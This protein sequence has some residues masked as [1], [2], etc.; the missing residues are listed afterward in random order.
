MFFHAPPAGVYFH[1]EPAVT[2]LGPRALVY[3]RYSEPSPESTPCCGIWPVGCPETACQVLP[4][5]V[6]R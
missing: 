2:P 6:E 1:T 4:P 3:V 5:S